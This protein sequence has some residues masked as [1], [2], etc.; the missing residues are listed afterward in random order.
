MNKTLD[1]LCDAIKKILNRL[2]SQSQPLSFVLL[3]GIKEEGKTTL[4]R[5][6]KLHAYSF[7]SECDINL[8]YN[9]HGIILELDD[10]WINRNENLLANTFKR[11]NHCHPNSRISGLL[12]CVDSSHLLSLDSSQLTEH[13]ARYRQLLE[14]IGQAL[15]YRIEAGIIFNKI[16]ALAGFS[17]F[18]QSEHQSDLIK[19][20]GFS[21]QQANNRKQFIEFFNRQFDMMLETL[22]QQTINKLHPARSSAKRT[23]IREFPLQLSSL[24]I[25]IQTILS[26][27]SP[28]LFRLQAIY[29][30]SAEQGGVSIDR[31]NK[32]IENEYALVVQDKFPQSNNYRPYFIQGAI[33]SFQKCTKYHRPRITLQHKSIALAT[34]STVGLL[35][36][37]LVYHHISAS[38]LLNEANNELINYELSIN[39][40]N[41]SSEAL[42][43]LTLAQ[44][45]LDAI[46][47]TPLA[48]SVIGQL[49]NQL[50]YGT[51]QQMHD[52]FL[53]H[54][55]S[56]LET[57]MLNAAET[58]FERYQALKIYLMLG[59]STHYSEAEVTHWFENYW[60]K[61]NPTVS[62]QR[63]VQLLKQALKQPVQSINIDQQIV[64][65]M[66]NYFNALP[67]TYLYYALAKKDFPAELRPISVS[68]T[69]LTLPT[70]YSV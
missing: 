35:L 42:Y 56:Q 8:Y 62:N 65:D 10:Y 19:P 12:F 2:K 47:T 54:I 48:S 31:L 53:P 44:A 11:L 7:D 69:H 66:R 33:F 70:I 50:Q 5:Q 58:Q 36:V 3:T 61:N 16:D 40:D 68:Y 37:G 45:K 20:L 28:K 17:E 25:P 29:F 23:L 43:H 63:D 13:C 27:V 55:I 52:N 34:C 64:R 4:L 46:R 67:M 32:K 39:K 9:D 18:F 38:R 49:R 1:L 60:K 59:D 26:Q 51:H 22:G 30:T 21:V 41:A 24:R 57:V 6:S 14:R 15:E